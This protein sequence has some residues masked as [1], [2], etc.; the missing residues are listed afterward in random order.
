MLETQG[1][2]KESCRQAQITPPPL[3]PPFLAPL[4]QRR[5]LQ[6]AETG[7]E[8]SENPPGFTH[9]VLSETK[10]RTVLARDMIPEHRASCLPSTLNVP[11]GSSLQ[12]GHVGTLAFKAHER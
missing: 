11:Q 4:A 12:D 3:L 5:E 8:S 2:D 1:S 6:A 7:V 10:S 9:D